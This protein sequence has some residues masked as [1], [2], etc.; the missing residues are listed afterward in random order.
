MVESLAYMKRDEYG[1]L[2]AV[3]F[4]ET[5]IFFAVIVILAVFFYTNYYRVIS[6]SHMS[7]AR[8]CVYETF[9]SALESYK[10]DIGEYP[11][12][13]QGLEAL[14][15]PPPGMEDRWRGPY[16]AA[17]LRDPWGR[18]YQYVYPSV[19][20]DGVFDLWSMGRDASSADDD[21]ANW[22]SDASSFR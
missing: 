11:S 8:T 13:F 18:E 20:G 17:S 14:V 1:N 16:V 5:A 9:P 6:R 4:I 19:H 10:I 21:I 2:A 12:T 22:K 7:V 15:A 3:S